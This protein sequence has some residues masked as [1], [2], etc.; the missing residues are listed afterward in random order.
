MAASTIGIT[1]KNWPIMPVTNSIGKKAAT[2]VS[3]PPISGLV[4]I[5]TTCADLSRSFPSFTSRLSS[6]LNV[7]SLL[8]AVMSSS[9]CPQ[10]PSTITIAV[11][12]NKPRDKINENND[13]PFNVVSVC[14]KT[15]NEIAKVKGTDKAVIS[16]GPHPR[17]NHNN[18]KTINS[19]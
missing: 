17:N 14:A 3:V 6:A 18:P 13:T 5:S 15:R 19:V 4:N 9:R 8:G 11:S 10:I 7:N 12:T 16:P 1:F 2:V